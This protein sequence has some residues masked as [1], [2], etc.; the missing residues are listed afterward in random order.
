M[1]L[2]FNLIEKSTQYSIDNLKNIERTDCP[3]L[4]FLKSFINPELLDKL[5]K[6]ISTEELSW[7]TETNQEY[8]NRLKLNWV[9]DTVVEEVHIVLE[10]L[11][12][13]LNQKF[14][15]NNKFIGLTVWKD[16]EGYTIGKHDKDN[17]IID[18]AIQIYLTEGVADLGTKFEYNNKILGTKYQKNHGYLYDNNQGVPHYMNTPVPK[19]HV[20]Y[21]LYAMWSKLN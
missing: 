9:F 18:L 15:R 2:K 12:V 16:Q 7:V 21:S 19:N 11:T 6:Y 14:N 10:N 5:L 1:T 3:Y 8:Q 20:R 17:S 4:F 13:E